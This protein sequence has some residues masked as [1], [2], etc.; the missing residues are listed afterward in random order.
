MTTAALPRKDFNMD[1]DTGN[2][3]TQPKAYAYTQY[4]ETYSVLAE[5]AFYHQVT[6]FMGTPKQNLCINLIEAETGEDFATLTVNLGEFISI[7]DS[8][9]I[10]TNNLPGI[11]KWLEDNGI[12]KMTGLTKQSGYCAYPLAVFDKEFLESIDH[13]RLAA[14]R[15]QFDFDKEIIE[16]PD[17]SIEIIEP[18]IRTV[19]AEE[20]AWAISANTVLGKELWFFEAHLAEDQESP[21]GEGFY[22]A[23]WKRDKEGNWS[24]YD[25]G[26][27]WGY[28]SATDLDE[29]IGETL[30][31][32]DYTH[33]LIPYE[34]FE[35]VCFYGDKSVEQNYA[36]SFSTKLP[37]QDQRERAYDVTI[38]ETLKRTV[39]V[40]AKSAD[41][42]HAKVED[43]WRD[44]VY[45]LD[46]DDF[47]EVHFTT[48]EQQRTQTSQKDRSERIGGSR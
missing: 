31:F 14:Y 48:R 30:P 28:S 1:T 19:A 5:P 40:R 7:K 35:A 27:Y 17:F 8:A 25:G 26:Q 45:V 38:C 12:A 16:E 46:A 18:K 15:E 3:S 6:D 39:S 43:D 29:V 13:G 2:T 36:D 21:T 23:S 34:D 4:D 20:A 9:Y 44:G 24:E 41:E 11:D 10:D 47:K 37:E 33:E 32:S 42:A 22:F